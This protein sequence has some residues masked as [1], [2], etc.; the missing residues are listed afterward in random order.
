[1][2]IGKGAAPAPPRIPSL[3]HIRGRRAA[4]EGPGFSPDVSPMS[5]QLTPS[6]H[7]A[8][9]RPATLRA[10]CP[11]STPSFAT[12]MDA[13]WPSR[14]GHR[15]SILC[16]PPRPRRS[17]IALRAIRYPLMLLRSQPPPSLSS[18]LLPDPAEVASAPSH[19]RPKLTLLASA[20]CTVPRVLRELVERHPARGG[21]VALVDPDDSRREASARTLWRFLARQGVTGWVLVATADARR[22]LPG[23]S[24]VLALTAERP[25]SA[26]TRRPRPPR[27]CPSVAKLS[28]GPRGRGLSLKRAAA[29]PLTLRR[30]CAEL[31]PRAILLVD[32][33]PT[34]PRAIA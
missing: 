4:A 11:P 23:S 12:G 30:A 29:L 25:R 15:R 26:G 21:V 14:I 16:H 5:T 18:P 10:L 32:D 28:A 27:S 8:T 19:P 7:R 6:L 20:P 22:A 13:G 1:M 24:F 33:R 31:C 3:N 9:T 2:I 34:D 17:R